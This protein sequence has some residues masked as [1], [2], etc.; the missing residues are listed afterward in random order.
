[1]ATAKQKTA[2]I[3]ARFSSDLQKDRSI[4]DQFAVC[5]AYANRDGIRI[6]ARFK[7]RAKS[8]ASL[9]DRD[10]LMDLRNAAKRKEF[11]AIIVENL[12]RMSRDQ[13]D[14]A[15]LFKR[16]QHYG[17][18]LLTVNEGKTTSMHVGIRGL[19]GSMF[20][21]DLA[22]KVKRGHDGRVRAGKVPG[23]VTYGYD[24]VLGQ[25]GDRVINPA[26]AEVVRRIFREYADGISPRFIALGLTRDGIPTPSGG[27]HWNHQT[28]VG[29]SYAR[30]IV[31]NL[32]YIGKLQWNTHYIVTDPDTGSK[33]KRPT[34]ASKHLTVD[35]PDLRIIDQPLWDAAAAVRGSRAVSKFGPEGKRGPQHATRN[36]DSFLAG[37]LVCGSCHGHMRIAQC[38]R[39]GSARVACAS[40]HQRDTCAHRKSYDMGELE[41][42]VLDGF[43]DLTD[44]KPITE[45]IKAYHQRYA[46]NVKT[47]GAER[48]SVERQLNRLT[49]Q[50]DRLVTAISDTNEPLPALMESLKA[51]EAQRVGLQERARLLNSSNVISLH[52]NFIETYKANV[53]RLH[54]ALTTNIGRAQARAAFHNLVDSIVVHPTAK[55]MPYEVNVYGRLAAIMGVDLFPTMR[56]NE[57]IVAAEAIPAVAIPSTQISPSCRYSNSQKDGVVS[58]GR[59]R[60]AA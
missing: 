21:T 45:A 26:E 42:L 51:K 44:T 57:E 25:P 40:A 2:A 17:I 35:V 33:L 54:E 38:S 49:L 36:R 28:F 56:T 23:A 16:F 24:R 43:R 18:E 8:G 4:D 13:E 46:E 22:A 14:L 9:F 39:N 32:L 31:G 29:G 52:P 58:L 50:I 5:E 60:Q 20:L 7:D 15:G 6:V 27:K 37:L 30:G 53:T 47:Q 55:R 41:K 3:Y 59:W 12:D 19:V 11:D 10:G 48:L 34:D 1:M